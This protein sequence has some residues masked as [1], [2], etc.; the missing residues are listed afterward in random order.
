MTLRIA[1]NINNINKMAISIAVMTM[2]IRILRITQ[3]VLGIIQMI[4]TI[5]ENKADNNI[6]NRN[7]LDKAPTQTY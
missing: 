3:F 4:L 7:M 5:V 6:Q 2:T 1:S